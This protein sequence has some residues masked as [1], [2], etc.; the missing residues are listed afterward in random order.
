MNRL[1]SAKIAF[2]VATF[3]LAGVVAAQGQTYSVLFEF[4][5]GDGYGANVLTQ[6]TDGNLYGTTPQGGSTIGGNAAGFG[7]AF[8]VSPAGEFKSFYKFCSLAECADGWNPGSLVLG[9]NAGFYGTTWWGGTGKPNGCGSE[10]CGGTFFEIAPNETL[11]TLYDFCQAEKCAD[12]S[13]P[14]SAPVLGYD[15]NYYGTTLQ[16]GILGPCP[17]G[18]GTVYDITTTGTLTT[19][20]SLCAVRSNCDGS[21]CCLTGII[22][23]SNGNFYGLQTNQGEPPIPGV[24]FEITSEGTF[25]ALSANVGSDPVVLI[26]GSDGNLYGENEA[27]IFKVTPSGELTTLYT[28][29]SLKNC[30]DGAEPNSLIEGSDGNFYGTTEWG[31]KTNGTCDP[32]PGC[33]VIFEITPAGV[34]SVLYAFCSQN[35]SSGYWPGGLMQ[36]TNGTFY[37]GTEVGGTPGKCYLERGCGVIFSLDVGLAPFVEAN[38]GFSGAGIVVDI[39]G[40][41]LTETSSVTF[42]G[43]AAKFTV[44]SA[45]LIH[46]TVPA[47]ATTGT[48]QVTTPT[49]TLSSNAAFQVL[50]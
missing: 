4:N 33:G 26:Q 45:T 48:I 50:P 8:R 9:V 35:C 37:G 20:H 10:E 49:G 25:S 36:A 21:Q 15:G 28:F 43:V 46:A 40:N 29:C 42:N 27:T 30:A 5:G 18:C 13:N 3:C 12:G 14:A 11:T 23:G 6:G 7:T 31:G 41:N 2:V 22:L 24:I 19:L 1:G 39:L 47:G 44:V 17:G 16:G 34:Y 32:E 38:P